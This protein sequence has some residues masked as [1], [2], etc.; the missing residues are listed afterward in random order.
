MLAPD[1]I[2][3][4]YEQFSVH[5]K[6]VPE[7][8]REMVNIVAYMKQAKEKLVVEQWEAVQTSLVRLSYLL[9]VHTFTAEDMLLNQVTLT[10]PAKLTSIFRVGNIGWMG[11]ISI[12]EDTLICSLRVGNI[13]W[14]GSVSIAEDTLIC[15]LRV[16]NIGWMGSISIAEDTLICSLRVGNNGWMGSV[17]IAE[18]TLICSLRVGKCINWLDG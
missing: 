3:S 17:S 7:D 16:G 15:S 8:S 4:E 12:A 9:D 2:C 14:M 18:D 10:W 5:A 6:K 13:G 1:R 11:S